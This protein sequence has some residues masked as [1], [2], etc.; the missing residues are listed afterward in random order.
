MFSNI[1]RAFKSLPV[2]FLWVIFIVG[3]FNHSLVA[4]PSSSL[5]GSETGVRPLF[6]ESNP[7]SGSDEIG[8]SSIHLSS[9]PI[10][11]GSSSRFK[12]ERK[13]RKVLERTPCLCEPQPELIPSSSFYNLT[14]SVPEE[15]PVGSSLSCLIRGPPFQS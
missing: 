15:S 4:C 7:S 3:F 9:T 10:Q 12:L 13:R 2:S 14:F 1:K 8:I 6:Q 5:T 11:I